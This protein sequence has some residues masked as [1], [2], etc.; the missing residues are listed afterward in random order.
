VPASQQGSQLGVP[1]LEVEH[2]QIR[3]RA[4]RIA[5]AAAAGNEAE[6]RAGFTFLA[7]YLDE[8]F[9][10]EERWMEEEGYPGLLEHARAHAAIAARLTEARRALE[11]VGTPARAVKEVARE[12]E[13]HVN[14]DDQRLVRFHAAKESL[15]RMAN[16]AVEGGLDTAPAGAPAGPIRS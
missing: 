16:R 7:H 10:N 8:H 6:V 9:R 2:R 12:L 13:R 5:A 14:E 15:R 3:R 4:E 11:L 1:Q